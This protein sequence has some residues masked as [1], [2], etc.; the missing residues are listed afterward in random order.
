MYCSFANIL[1][2]DMMLSTVLSYCSQS[3]LLL[4]VSVRNMFVT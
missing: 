1:H 2:A 3:L 4:F